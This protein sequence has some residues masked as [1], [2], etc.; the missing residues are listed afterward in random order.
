MAS[1]LDALLGAGDADVGARVV[2]SWNSDLGGGLQLQLLQLLTVLTD[3]ETMV[4]FGDGDRSGRLKGEET[5]LLA[6][7]HGGNDTLQL[8]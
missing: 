3:D 2:G 5:C 1:L 4:L 8:Q 6:P 7:L